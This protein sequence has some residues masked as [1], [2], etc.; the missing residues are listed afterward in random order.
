MSAAAERSGPSENYAWGALLLLLSM[1]LAAAWCVLGVQLYLGA[2]IQPLTML[3]VAALALF[4]YALNGLSDRTEDAF[5][6]PARAEALR[7]SAWWTL[8]SSL[9]A[10]LVAGGLLVTRQRLHALYPALMGVAVAYS[11]RVVPWPRRSG[12]EWLRLKDVSLVKNLTIGATWASAV[13]LAPWFDLPERERAPAAT[14]F[15]VAAYALLV[16][17]N[18]IF[19]DLRD[20]AG[21]RQAGVQTL[22]VRFGAERC[23]RAIFVTTALWSA[24]VI[25]GLAQQKL[26]A[27]TVTFLLAS[28]WGYPLA[29]WCAARRFAPRRGL[30]NLVIESSDFLFALG[31]MALAP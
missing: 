3:M 2:G 17:V 13:F 8:G 20:E 16:V 7:R 22:A 1:P 9:A 28:A 18:S 11:Y 30:M 14:L 10:V 26:A 12:I 27:P 23:L 31:L 19:C 15:V 6:D 4:T 5:N 21:D 29:V 25:A 24:L